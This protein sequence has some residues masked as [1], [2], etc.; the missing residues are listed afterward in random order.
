MASCIARWEWRTFGESVPDVE[1]RLRSV[2]APPRTSSELYLV[3]PHADLNL[4]VRDGVLELK[5]LVDVSAEGL[6]RWMPTIKAPFPLGAAVVA[7]L[8]A[9]LRISTLPEGTLD[10]ARWLARLRP[11]PSLDLVAVRKLRRIG[12]YAGCT[13]EVADVWFDADATTSW[14]VEHADR[15]C[16]L[17]VL[18]E[19]GASPNRNISYPRAL[20]AFL[21]RPE[22]RVRRQ[23]GVIV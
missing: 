13:V 2:L 9:R 12:T 4:K 23:G 8:S 20:Q 18:R 15:E 22:R 19:C 10:E 3:V 17:A 7:R 6:E 1:S 14:A 5:E 21:A 11:L 16:V